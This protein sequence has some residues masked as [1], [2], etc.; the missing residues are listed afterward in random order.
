M[1]KSD[2]PFH[3]LDA[4]NNRRYKVTTGQSPNI[5]WVES[6]EVK[7]SDWAGYIRIAED[8][9]YTFKIQVDDNGFIE[10]DGKKVVEVT[11]S[12]SST[13]KEGTTHLKKG[14][15][16]A[17]FHH[18]NLAVPDEI[19]PYPNATQFEAFLDGKAVELKD[20]DAPNN[21]WKKADAQ[22]LL[23]CYNVV[24]YP[25]KSSTKVWEFIGGWL[26][27][28]YHDENS[29]ALRLSI[30]LSSYGIDLKN[31]P[32]ANNIIDGNSENIGGKKHVVICTVKYL[33]KHI[34]EV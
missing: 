31:A 17:K 22:R 23:S 29:C 7:S 25:T 34:R 5:P 20:I 2:K 18:E 15:H 30:G 32:G 24:D 19:K 12:N 1:A 21:L 9:D 33:A 10:I 3:P 28:D 11:G 8:G 26:D 13:S 16:Y 27:R 4:E 6:E 14:F